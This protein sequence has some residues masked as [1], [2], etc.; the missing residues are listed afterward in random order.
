M[1]RFITLRRKIYYFCLVDNAKNTFL[2][3]LED[4]YCEN[5]IFEI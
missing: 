3:Q 1:I 5:L 2:T 4:E